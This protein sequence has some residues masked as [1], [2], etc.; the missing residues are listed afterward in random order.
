MSKIVYIASP[1]AGDV[2]G[3]TAFAINACRY[4][5]AQGYTPVAPHLLYTQILDDG[6]PVQ[7]KIGLAL[8]R[9]LLGA[10]AEIWLCGERVSP[11]MAAEIEEAERLGIPLRRVG[12]QEIHEG[13]QRINA[14]E[15]A[16]ERTMGREMSMI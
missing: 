8:G 16:V 14:A 15:P 9:H 1:Y 10:T 3:N 6:D 13:I 5:I 7:R 4:C 2:A 11:G 12:T